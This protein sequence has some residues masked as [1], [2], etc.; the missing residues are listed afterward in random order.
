MTIDEAIEN[1]YQQLKEGQAL[2]AV[3]NSGGK[4]RAIAGTIFEK[5]CSDLVACT[6]RT[7]HSKRFIRS[8]SI[9]G[10]FLPKLQVDRHISFNGQIESVCEC[11]TYLDFCYYKRAISDFHEVLLSPD[12]TTG[13]KLA[14]FTGQ[15]S[16]DDN[17]LAFSN[18]VSRKENGVTPE[19]FV[20]NVVKQRSSSRQL[21]DPDC[22]ADFQLDE[23]ELRRFID[24][25]SE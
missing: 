11:K 21:L 20:V 15:R 13:L 25:V 7:I 24:W 14:V 18:A 17:S 22:A 2:F 8:R 23:S 10:L 1:Y 3:P 19:L 12:I 9:E 6:D 4:R 5:L 16:L